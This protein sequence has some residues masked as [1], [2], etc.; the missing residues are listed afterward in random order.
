MARRDAEAPSAR[1]EPAGLAEVLASDLARIRHELIRLI[2]EIESG[3]E[4]EDAARIAFGALAGVA[5]T[6]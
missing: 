3:S 5:G 1:P 4:A 2:D 6:R